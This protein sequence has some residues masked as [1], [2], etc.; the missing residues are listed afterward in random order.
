MPA[1]VFIYGGSYCMTVHVHVLWGK[2]PSE[3]VTVVFHWCFLCIRGH[4]TWITVPQSL[5]LGEGTIYND[6]TLLA[7]VLLALSLHFKGKHSKQNY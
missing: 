5:P 6:P 1:L 4:W 3:S 2:E 7:I